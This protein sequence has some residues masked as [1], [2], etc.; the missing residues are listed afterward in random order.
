MWDKATGEHDIGMDLHVCILMCGELGKVGCDRS[1]QT[2]H[3]KCTV[4][5]KINSYVQV[6]GTESSRSVAAPVFCFF[7]LF[8][9]LNSI[10]LPC[11]S[12]GH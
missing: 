11:L 3:F 9:Q 1:L 8:P 2:G 7:S 12:V 10:D 6:H 5:V 4:R